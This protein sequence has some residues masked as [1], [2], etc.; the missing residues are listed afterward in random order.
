MRGWT[1]VP[2]AVVNWTNGD[3]RALGKK[4]F[5]VAEACDGKRDFSSLS[6]IP[7]HNT[8]LDRLIREEIA[9]ECEEGASIDLSQR[10]RKA[11]NP[12]L[13]GLHWSVT[14]LCNLNCRHCYVEAPSGRYG[15]LPFE[16]AMRLVEQFELANVQEVSLTGGEPFLRKDLPD[17]VAG[18]AQKKIWLSQIYTNGLLI[19]EE[20]LEEIKRV[21]FLPAFQISFDGRGAHEYM[22]GRGGIEQGVIEAITKVRVAGFP[23]VISTCVDSVNI[24]HLADTYDLLKELAIGYWRILPPQKI[25]NW[26]GTKTGLSLEDEVEFYAPLLARWLRDGRPFYLQLGRLFTGAGKDNPVP[27]DGPGTRYTPESY[28]CG[29]CREQRYVLPDGTLL[30][31]AGYT[32]SALH[33]RMPN[34]LR[35]GLSKALSGSLLCSIANRKKADLLTR[36]TECTSCESFG[37][38]GMGCRAVALVETG[39]M[40][41]KDPVAC[42]MWKKGYRQRLRELAG[43]GQ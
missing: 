35:D 41:A 5:Y 16:D 20:V 30:P 32:D 13:S 33:R 31:C 36:N 1:D 27:Q 7:V 28:D 34:I 11:E 18:L 8:F 17:I 40:M 23:V 37:E 4:G 22:R 39:D 10:Y 25:G 24:G 26:K 12:R 9:E 14:G 3:Q 38:C 42:E 21:G 43:M 15:E 2:L 29:G 19:K 6:F